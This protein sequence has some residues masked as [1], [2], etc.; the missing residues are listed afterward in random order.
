MGMGRDVSYLVYERRLFL[1]SM[2][3]G[4]QKVSQQQTDI[5]NKSYKRSKLQHTPC[6]QEPRFS[7]EAELSILRPKIQGQEPT[8]VVHKTYPI[9]L[10]LQRLPMEPA[11]PRDFNHQVS[12]DPY[13]RQWASWGR[14]ISKYR[15]Y[16]YSRQ[17]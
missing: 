13:F 17:I 2:C 3:P 7:I 11:N 8:Q 16:F 4:T 6:E 5:T 10:N 14:A 12:N 15:A 1:T 9:L